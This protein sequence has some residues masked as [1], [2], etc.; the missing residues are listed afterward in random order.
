ME[1]VDLSKLGFDFIEKSFPCGVL[2][3]T[4]YPALKIKYA[5]ETLIKM[6]VYPNTS[7]EELYNG[8][9]LVET[10]DLPTDKK[11]TVSVLAGHRGGSNGQYSFLNIDKLESGDKIKI[12]YSEN[13]L[14]YTVYDK[15]VVESTDWSKF[16]REK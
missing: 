10:T 12:I 2:I 9:G 4:T 1:I 16:T 3:T 6:L 8:V 13:Q 15:I 5:N 7:S 11:N 14:T